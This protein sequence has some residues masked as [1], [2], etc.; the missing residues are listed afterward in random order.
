MFV[1]LVGGPLGGGEG[2][3]GSGC[4]LNEKKLKLKKSVHYLKLFSPRWRQISVLPAIHKHLCPSVEC[5]SGFG[6]SLNALSL[7]ACTFD[8]GTGQEDHEPGVPVAEGRVCAGG[9][10]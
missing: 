5:N 2:G 1:S 7:V 6:V 8:L 10:L 4:K 3:L 9:I